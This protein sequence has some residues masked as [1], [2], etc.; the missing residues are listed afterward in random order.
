MEEN[1][2]LDEK[3]LSLMKKEQIILQD[4]WKLRREKI[5]F[6][7]CSGLHTKTL[8]LA[9]KTIFGSLYLI[10]S[11]PSG[12]LYLITGSLYLITARTQKTSA[13]FI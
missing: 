1:R 4:R 11:A 10:I 7:I 2:K 3:Q 6:G 8:R 5:S 9:H 13:H 12:S